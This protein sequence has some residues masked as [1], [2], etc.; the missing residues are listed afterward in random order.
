MFPCSALEMFAECSGNMVYVMLSIADL[1]CLYLFVLT[2]QGDI[3]EV[4]VIPELPEGTAD[5]ALEIIPAETELFRRHFAATHFFSV[6]VLESG[7]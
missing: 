4:L 2:G 3:K 7:N 6:E 5:V 1:M